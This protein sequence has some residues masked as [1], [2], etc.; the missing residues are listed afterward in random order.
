MLCNA[1][2]L[3]LAWKRTLELASVRQMTQEPGYSQQ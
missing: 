2:S 1:S 3:V